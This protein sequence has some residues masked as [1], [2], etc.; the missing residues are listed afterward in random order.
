ML[1]RISKLSFNLLLVLLSTVQASD[2]VSA[3]AAV[4]LN[5]T[6]YQLEIA[7]NNRSRTR[8][9]MFRRH[10]AVNH[11][12]LFVYPQADDHRIWMKNTLLPLTV[13]WFDTQAR[14]IDKQLLLPCV[15]PPCPVYSA[16]VDSRLILELAASEFDKFQVG[17]RFPELMNWI[18]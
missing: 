1:T 17:E 12:M 8:G 6:P 16:P 11:G 10:L 13:I 18:D 3:R 9:L 15:S 7:D 2:P 5:N 14:I 4:I